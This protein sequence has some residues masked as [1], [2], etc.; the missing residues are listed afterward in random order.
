MRSFLYYIIWTILL[1]VIIYFGTMFHLNLKASMRYDDYYIP[2]LLYVI[3]FP[4]VVGMLLRLPKTI[5][6]LRGNQQKSYDW[7]KLLAINIPIILFLFIPIINYTSEILPY[8][9]IQPLMIVDNIL[10][11]TI[12]GIVFGYVILDCIKTKAV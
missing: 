12:A 4:I 1:S 2:Y 3:L 6:V 11:M 7:I 9:L 5:H 8:F 10:L